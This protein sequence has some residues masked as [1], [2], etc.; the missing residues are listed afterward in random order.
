MK[1]DM[2]GRIFVR[3]CDGSRW[4]VRTVFQDIVYLVSA[5]GQCQDCPTFRELE[6]DYTEVEN[7]G[8]T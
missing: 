5:N 6:E 8:S 7:G 4:T 2:I 1:S 3:T